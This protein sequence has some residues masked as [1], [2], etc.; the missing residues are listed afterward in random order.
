MGPVGLYWDQWEIGQRWE[1]FPRTVT[2][3]DLMNFVGVTGMFERLFL[4]AEYILHE[5]GYGKRLV[6]AALTFAMAEGLVLQL[7]LIHETA[8]AFLGATLNTKA[9]VGVGDTI[10]VEVEV[11]EKRASS[12]PDRGLVRTLNRVLDQ[13]GSVVLEYDPLRLLKRRPEGKPLP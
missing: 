3:T 2:E 13:K 9:P 8:I 6:P 1:T 11:T 5:S 12:K 4:D 10:H 7:G